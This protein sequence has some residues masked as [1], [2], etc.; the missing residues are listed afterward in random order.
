MNY[1]SS[2]QKSYISSKS[3]VCLSSGVCTKPDGNYIFLRTFKL[4]KVRRIMWI[5]AK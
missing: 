5:L 1:N 2:V 4:R 3:N